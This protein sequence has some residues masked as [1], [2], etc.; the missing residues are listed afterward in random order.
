MFSKKEKDKVEV[1]I[2]KLNDVITISHKILKIFYILLVIVGIYTLTILFKELHLKQTLAIVLKTISP[3]FI[4]MFIAWLFDP[5]VKWLKTKGVRRG[6]GT[7]ITYLLFI[8]LLVILIG[9]II[10]VLSSQINDF[11]KTM[12]S[13]FDSVQTWMNGIFENLN[14]I[15]GFDAM[16]VKNQIFSKIQEFGTGLTNSLPETMMN[17][18]STFFSGAGSFVVGLI[19]G[20]YLLMSFDNASD[21]IITLLPKRMQK[22]TRGLVN[23]VNTSL[24]R[25]VQGALIDCTLIFIVTSLGLWLAGL[26]APLLFGLFCGITNIIPFAGPYI[27]GAPAVIVGFSQSP[28]TGIFTLLVI[29][30]IQFFEGNF[31]QPLIMSKTTKLHPVTIIIGLLVFGYFFGILGMAISTPIIASLKAIFMFF[32]EKYGILN[33]NDSKQ[34]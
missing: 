18:V 10:P 14:H 15:E 30:I 13:I 12:P 11:V 2:P 28:L 33:Y 5:F 23:D 21:L 31:L 8:G 1:D 27:G 26:K 16:E 29:V 24:R 22:D 9:S 34:E 25:F 7:T 17:F 32:D 19:I 3:L 4:G 20:F 6:V